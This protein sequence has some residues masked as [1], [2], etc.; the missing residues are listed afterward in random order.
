MKKICL[1]ISL[2]LVAVM[3]FSSCASTLTPISAG[4]YDKKTDTYYAYAPMCY[5]ATG[6]QNE[7]YIKDNIGFEYHIV[8]D[9][10]GNEA[11]PTLFLYDKAN[12]TLIY[13]SANTLPNLAELN[14]TEM[15]FAVEGSVST[16]L[17]TETDKMSIDKV[18]DICLNAPICKYPAL[19]T[20][21]YYKLKFYSADHPYILYSIS[22]LEYDYD[23]CEY[24]SAATLENYVY[25]T[26]VEYTVIQESD[27]SYTI[28][29][30]YGKYFVYNRDSGECRMAKYI[31][32]AYNSSE[33]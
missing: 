26:G 25:R 22:Y 11:D 12:K 27:G 5:E 4:F 2:L 31:H 24:E 15:F 7:S 3:L 13:N 9:S 1:A 17:T 32:D 33:D 21:E 28:E 10:S 30:N 20:D 19:Q 6:W 23:Y 14:P 8:L 29:Y 16:T 18:I